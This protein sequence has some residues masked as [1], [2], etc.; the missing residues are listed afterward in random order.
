MS[1]R[2][3]SY[4]D[5]L[6]EGINVTE[7]HPL[8][9]LYKFRENGSV[10]FQNFPIVPDCSKIL[11]IREEQYP[12]TVTI[13]KIDQDSK[14][15]WGV[16]LW[17][18]QV[19]TTCTW[20]FW[21]TYKGSE[22]GRSLV[23][24][25]LTSQQLDYYFNQ[26]EG[27]TLEVDQIDYKYKYYCYYC[28]NES[29]LE[30]LE[31]QDHPPAEEQEET[32]EASPQE[33]DST[34]LTPKRPQPTQTSSPPVKR[35]LSFNRP[36]KKA[37]MMTTGERY[38]STTS[39]TEPTNQDLP[40]DGTS[41][42]D[43]SLALQIQKTN[44]K[45]V[46][47]IFQLCTP[48]NITHLLGKSSASMRGQEGRI[49]ISF[50]S[51]PQKTGDIIV[52]LAK[53]LEPNSINVPK[54]HVF[55]AC[56]STLLPAL[57]VQHLKTFSPEAT[58]TLQNVQLTHWDM[59]HNGKQ[60]TT[61]QVPK[62][63]ITYFQYKAQ[64]ETQLTQEWVKELLY[65]M[66]TYL[67]TNYPYEESL[68]SVRGTSMTL[69]LNRVPLPTNENNYFKEEIKNMCEKI[70]SL[71]SN[72]VQTRLLTKGKQHSYYAKLLRGLPYNSKKTLNNELKQQYILPKHWYFKN[73]Q[74]KDSS[75][76]T[77]LNSQETQTP[78]HTPQ[79]TKE[80]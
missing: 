46:Q 4:P 78:T 25:F 68:V 6:L 35:S 69:E 3:L 54:L 59:Y 77:N 21:G 79:Y 39:Q 75:D 44:S 70:K 40:T 19:Q 51:A 55:S 49:T 28:V 29:H 5:G 58:R 16:L 41:P 66:K 30:E 65:P 20:E 53:L 24:T 43:G 61:L 13:W 27:E 42:T 64:H 56:M 12:T 38:T 8:T 31:S 34:S 14:A 80:Y 7:V 11:D 63:E 71:C 23:E 74:S 45:I 9:P 52:A 72:Y 10:V 57:L 33:E 26:D 48:Q 73:Q 36:P 47:Q 22:I 17:T 62:G 15:E 76:S 67:K 1:D 32:E 60:I 18:E 37:R 2:P 50:T